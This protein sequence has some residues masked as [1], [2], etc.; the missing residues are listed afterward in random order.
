MGLLKGLDHAETSLKLFEGDIYNPTD[1]A[2]AIDGCEF[3]FHIATP[4]QHHKGSQV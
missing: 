4:M 3:V 2:A 1:F